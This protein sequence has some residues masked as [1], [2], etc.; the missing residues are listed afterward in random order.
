MGMPF[1]QD[2]DRAAATQWILANP[3]HPVLRPCTYTRTYPQILVVTY[4]VGAHVLHSL[5]EQD[6]DAFYSVLWARN[7]SWTRETRYSSA[8]SLEKTLL[9]LLN[10][11]ADEDPAPYEVS[12]DP[13]PV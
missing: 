1:F 2:M 8:Q 11:E 6:G 5:V 4:R 10:P 3:L 7:G 9:L 13:I 12:E